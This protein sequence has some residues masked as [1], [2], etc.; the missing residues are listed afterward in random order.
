MKEMIKEI[1]ELLPLPLQFLIILGLIL[2]TLGFVVGIGSFIGMYFF[3]SAILAYSY[4]LF[5][6][7]LVDA[8]ILLI[9]AAVILFK[10]KN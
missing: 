8:L 3:G 7:G 2:A 1:L 9:V 6:W 5:F 10:I 4:G